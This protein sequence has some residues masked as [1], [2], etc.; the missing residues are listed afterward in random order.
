MADTTRIAVIGT[1]GR[2][3]QLVMD[4]FERMKVATLCAIRELGYEPEN[5]VLVSGGAPWADHVAV[6]LFL[7]GKVAGLRLHLPGTLVT[8]PE[9]TY[10]TGTDDCT[11]FSRY[12]ANFKKTTGLDGMAQIKRAI[13]QGATVNEYKGYFQRNKAIAAD[14]KALVAMHTNFRHPS[15]QTSGGT[16]YTF[17]QAKVPKLYIPFRDAKRKPRDYSEL[18][19]SVF[20]VIGIRNVFKRIRDSKGPINKFFKRKAEDLSDSGAAKRQKSLPPSPL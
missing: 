6:W 7:K 3:G 2:K 19:F 20:E 1:A 9:R 15:L 4:D 14:C 18:G 13:E 10:L 11:T 5:V 16:V 17:K 12:H 8:D